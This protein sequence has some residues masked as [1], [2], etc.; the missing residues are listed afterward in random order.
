MMMYTGPR[1]VTQETVFNSFIKPIEQGRIFSGYQGDARHMAERLGFPTER[2]D[3]AERIGY[4]RKFDNYLD[5]MRDGATHLYRPARALIDS[6]VNFIDPKAALGEL[7]VA[8]EVGKEA[9][10]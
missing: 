10:L 4:G 9:E 2:V 7:E 6:G 5:C 8:L 3:E 1:N